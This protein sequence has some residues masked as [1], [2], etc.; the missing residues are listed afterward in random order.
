LTLPL[1]RRLA[2]VLVD[3]RRYAS[4]EKLFFAGRLFAVY[5][6]RKYLSVK[7]RS[8]LDFIVRD[9][10]EVAAMLPDLA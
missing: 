4:R 3:P 8:F 10:F 1:V 9:S 5:P 6:S 2:D 7:V